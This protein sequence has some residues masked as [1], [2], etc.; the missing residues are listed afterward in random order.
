M[1]I[2]FS[3]Q[4][5]VLKHAESVSALF[6]YTDNIRI[7]DALE[8]HALI[9]TAQA[10][11]LREAYKAYRALGHRQTLQ[12]RKGTLSDDSFAELRKEVS[13]VWHEIFAE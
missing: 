1:D 13:G 3:V 4:Y 8:S 7:L 11:T 5:L 6:E 9:T 2:E 12:N 10:Q